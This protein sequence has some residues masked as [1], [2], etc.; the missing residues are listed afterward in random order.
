MRK[1]T[2]EQ[3]A[4]LT[5][6]GEVVLRFPFCS[7]LVDDL[8][9]EIPYRFRKYAPTSK[10][11]T[12]EADY[13]DLA[14]HLL[15]RYFPDAEVPAR[16]RV[17]APWEEPPPWEAPPPSA[18]GNDHYRVLHL[19]PT[20]PVELIE[21]AYRT[22]ARLHHPDRGGDVVAMQRVNAAYHALKARVSA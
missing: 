3:Q 8:K 13:A 16:W 4:R 22:L 19:L 7:A 20:A 17:R 1:D 11:W 18:G 5:A 9:A 2:R 14:V 12:V 21:S 10:E 15:L 6:F